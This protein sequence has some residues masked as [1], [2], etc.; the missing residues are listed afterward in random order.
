M[1]YLMIFIRCYYLSSNFLWYFK[2][3]LFNFKTNQNKDYWSERCFKQLIYQ[4]FD[5]Y[6]VHS[7]FTVSCSDDNW[8]A[9][10]G[11][12]FKTGLH[13]G[14][15]DCGVHLRRYD[16]NQVVAFCSQKSQRAHTKISPGKSIILKII[17]RYSVDTL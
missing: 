17:K 4:L 14:T 8:S 11:F 15:P 12:C 10:T 1:Y 13:W 9:L 2:V 6:F 7:L 3:K 5:N 16:E